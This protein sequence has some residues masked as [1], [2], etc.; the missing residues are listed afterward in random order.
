MKRKSYFPHKIAKILFFVILS[1]LIFSSCAKKDSF[2]SLSGKVTIGPL[3][4]VEPCDMTP[5]QI[6]Q[7]YNKRKILIYP[8][9]DTTLLYKE[10]D[11]YPDSL[12]HVFLLTG[13]YIVDINHLGVDRS[14]DVPAK[15]T[16]KPNVTDTLNIDI[17]TGIR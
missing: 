13:T 7:V 3:C 4:P 10:V 8:A 1:G 2:G 9:S 14:G 16:I 5:E 12:Y 11:I 15:I 17:D 6:N